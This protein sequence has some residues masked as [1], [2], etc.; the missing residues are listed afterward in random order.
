MGVPTKPLSL[1]NANA[2]T[3]DIESSW[4]S[5][6]AAVDPAVFATFDSLPEAGHD[7]HQG[8]HLRRYAARLGNEW[9]IAVA[10]RFEDEI[11]GR[12]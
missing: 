12:D 1:S 2:A 3:R 9:A 8:N 10:K 4:R 6:I 11:W 7:V 5:D